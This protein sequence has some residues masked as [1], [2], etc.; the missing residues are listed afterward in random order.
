MTHPKNPVPSQSPVKPPGLSQGPLHGQTDATASREQV[1]ATAP[2]VNAPRES[3]RQ[4]ERSSKN[5]SGG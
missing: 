5:R 3:K 2:P 1:R 4:Q